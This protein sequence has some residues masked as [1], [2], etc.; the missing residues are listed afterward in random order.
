MNSK[1]LSEATQV[2][3]G[4]RCQGSMQRKRDKYACIFYDNN[5]K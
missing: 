5:Q 2:Y 1:S 3:V 4:V